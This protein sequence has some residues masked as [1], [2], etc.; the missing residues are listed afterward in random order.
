MK[1]YLDQLWPTT[2]TLK[3]PTVLFLVFTVCFSFW[4]Y[5]FW[6]PYNSSKK[7]SQFHYDIFNYYSYLPAYFC[8][9]GSF[10]FE[11]F[12]P[13]NYNAIG[14]KQ[15]HIPKTTY[16]MAFLYSP[17]FA[18]GYKIAYNSQT[19]LNG[20]TE[21]FVYTLHAGSIF[22]ILLGLFF[23]RKFL[24][25]YFS[26]TVV[27][28]TLFATLF[29]TMLF[30]YTY[31][32]SEM[33]H[34]YLFCLFSLF[35]LL[36]DRWHKVQK[37]STTILLAFTIGFISLIRP[38][39]ILFFLIFIFWNVRS[40]KEVKV[41]FRFLADRYLHLLVILLIGILIWI[42]QFLFWKQHTGM[43]FYFSY[44]GEKFF[45]NDP[46]IFNI[47]F[48]YRKGWITYT[49]LIVLAFIGIFF[50]KKDFPLAKSFFLIFTL[51]IVY[52]LSCWWDWFFGGCFGSRG[53]CQH[54]AYLSIPLAFLLEKVLNLT[55]KFKLNGLITLV[56][57]VFIFSCICLNIGQSYQYLEKK[58]H[59]FGMTEKV[60]WEVFRKYKF[61]DNWQTFY[62]D[63]IELPDYEKLKSGESR[64]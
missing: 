25:S 64:E 42:P 62:N 56:T 2:D 17:F 30:I 36:C 21:E 7:E 47:L 41:K 60:Y 12:I 52:I 6:T 24:L 48:S 23:L 3:K 9:N 58:I 16:G 19:P 27:A 32:F 50:I 1:K 44:P 26:E 55:T 51:L 45:W 40:W 15:T 20:F 11:G 22:Y 39:E 10:E 54:I 34:G 43:Y 46:Q 4:F 29:G 28:I 37:W 8:N 61:D 49:P 53:F 57:M 14:P 59:P 31:S 33:T 38:T 63:N 5:D 13:S 35:L 18:L